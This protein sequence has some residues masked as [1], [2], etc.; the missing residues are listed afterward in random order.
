[1]AC[2]GVGEATGLGIEDA[3]E[4]GDEHVRRDTGGQRL[5]G[6]REY[7]A[8][9]VYSEGGGPHHAACCS[10]HQGRRDTLASGVPHDEAY[11]AIFEFEEVVEVSSHLTGWLIVGS[12]LPALQ[13]GYFL[14]E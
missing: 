4:A 6:P 8:R 14:G 10:H 7:L 9:R 2:V 3:I 11:P 1:M 13:I 12:D 5:V